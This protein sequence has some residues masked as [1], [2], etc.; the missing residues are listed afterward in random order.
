MIVRLFRYKGKQT[1]L[2]KV[3]N[4]KGTNI[5]MNEDFTDA[6]RQKR[7]ELLPEMR[8][9]RARGEWAYL[10]YD[11]LVVKPRRD[12]QSSSS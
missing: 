2:S 9:D 4:L 5:Y 10:K 12:H 1:I 6:V 3:N 7:K 11:K 8:A